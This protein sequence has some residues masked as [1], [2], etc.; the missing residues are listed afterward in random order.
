[1]IL[2]LF[3]GF[4]LATIGFLSPAMLNMT[5]VRTTIDKGRRAGIFFALGASSVNALQSLIAFAFLRFL[6][7]NPDVIDWLKRLGVIVLLSL[8]YF[9]YQQSKKVISGREES[10]THPLLL[11][12][13]LSTINMLALPY[14]FTS[15]LALEAGDQITA[16][17]PFIYFMAIGVFLGGFMM[18]SLY[19][20][21][22]EI[23]AKRSEFITR[24]LNLLLSILFTILGLAVLVDLL[25]L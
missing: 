9:F 17:T 8:A 25:F 3:F 4:L 12:A 19:A 24:N 16:I 6:D 20:F 5:T 11:G 13:F 7:S 21:L 22:A 15:A 10:T 23:V 14:Y 2:H 18:F 1:M